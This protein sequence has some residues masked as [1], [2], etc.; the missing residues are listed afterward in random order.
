[1]VRP[2]S[3]TFASLVRDFRAGLEASTHAKAALDLTAS[4]CKTACAGGPSG[5]THAGLTR[6]A[7]R[8]RTVWFRRADTLRFAIAWREWLASPALSLKTLRPKAIAQV[9]AHFARISTS[10]SRGAADLASRQDFF[11]EARNHPDTALPPI[12]TRRD[13]RLCGKE[14]GKCKGGAG[15]WGLFSSSNLISSPAQ[16]GAQ[17]RQARRF[18]TLGPDLRREREG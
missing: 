15:G 2:R 8:P 7:N 12:V 16:A 11:P 9:W 13:R 6:R 17:S 4:A 1:M 18:M 5:Q 10:L 14:V 3:R